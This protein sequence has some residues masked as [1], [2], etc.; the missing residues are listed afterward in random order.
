MTASSFF[1]ACLNCSFDALVALDAVEDE[2]LKE[3]QAEDGSGLL[4]HQCGHELV[5]EMDRVM[6]R[7]LSSVPK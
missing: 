5:N 6:H 3:D 7:I 4:E 2:N 1:L